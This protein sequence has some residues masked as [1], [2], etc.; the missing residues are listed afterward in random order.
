MKREA[1]EKPPARIYLWAAGSVFR[2]A[3]LLDALLLSP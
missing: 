3:N 1:I 2:P